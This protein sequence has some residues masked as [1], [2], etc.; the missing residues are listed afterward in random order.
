MF[1][2][3]KAL[4][5]LRSAARWS[6]R[7]ARFCKVLLLAFVS[8]SGG[9]TAQAQSSLNVTDFGAIGD[10]GQFFV[11][12]TAGSPMMTT[13]NP[14][15]SADIGKTI[16]IFKVGV[17]T[18]GTNSYGVYSTNNLDLIATIT[19]V[20]NGTNIFIS[21]L[22]QAT[23]P[24]T[25]ATYGTDNT[26]AI[27][28][29]I[30]AAGPNATIT[31]PNGTFLCLPSFHIGADGYT[32]GAICLHRGGLH[33]LGSGATTLLA[34][35]A[36]RPEDFSAYGWGVHPYR[37]YLFE[38]VAPVTNDQPIV[39]ENLTLDGGLPQGNTDVHGIYVNE[40]DGLGW[41][42]GHC[43]WLCYDS[44]GGATGTATHQIF[45]NIVVQHWRG[46]MFKSIDQNANGNISI[47][48]SVFRDGDA[49]ALN[50][51]GS[52]DITGNRF[53]NLFQVAEYYQNYYTNTSYFQNNFITNITG[54][55]WAWNGG[56]WTAP[57]FIMQSNIF[58]LNGTG[59]NAIQ[60]MPAA[61]ICVLNNEIH[62]ADYMTAFNLGAIGAQGSVMNSNIVIAGNSIYA[63][64]KLTAVFGFG[65][66]GINGITGLAISNNSVSVLQ[67]IFAVIRGGPQQINVS[68]NNN[69]INCP[70][71]GFQTGA[72]GKNNSAYILIST[73]NTYTALP[74]Y[75]GSVQTNIVSYVG[76]PLQWLD[77]VPT[78]DTF[79]LDDSTP[80]QIPSGAYLAFDNRTNRWATY[81]GG[82]G[83]NVV[84]YPSCNMT[85]AV[86]LTNGSLVIFNWTGTAWTLSA[87][88]N[89]G[90]NN[91]G[92]GTSSPTSVI[93]SPPTNFRIVN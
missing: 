45:T 39:L 32:L 88:N 41:D 42:V 60:T 15:S 34:R 69:L 46:E 50:I 66:D 5:I 25:F 29:A 55:G 33:F 6:S 19:N 64:T 49:T 35:A 80:A 18:V 86:T 47:H 65:G 30:A 10:A 17:Q 13:V 24:N 26:P 93:P 73:N 87:A 75:H 68:F 79:V 44:A 90:A 53:E 36:F 72:P 48:N 14:L 52:W 58:Y 74:I 54:N 2:N 23:L 78:G 84:I 92:A 67:Q 61:N 40:I 51:Y 82:S 12:T 21:A 43:A 77:Y 16:E 63:P 38:V 20:V 27:R 11:N 9:L 85:T 28:Q 59:M 70:A 22:P 76:G 3:M 4:A 62:C 81:N 71:A 57:P 56:V 1:R 83:G 7:R 91:S 89:G 31:F 37:G 8:G